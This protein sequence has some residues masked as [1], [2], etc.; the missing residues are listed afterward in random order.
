MPCALQEGWVGRT[1][2][3]LA[4]GL[5]TMH[6]KTSKVHLVTIFAAAM[7]QPVVDVEMG[8]LYQVDGILEHYAEIQRLFV[9]MSKIF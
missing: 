6:I 3:M 5:D 7:V 9:S 4:E 2:E 1:P 8:A